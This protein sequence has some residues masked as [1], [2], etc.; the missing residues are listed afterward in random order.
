MDIPWRLPGRGIGKPEKVLGEHGTRGRFLFERTRSLALRDEAT[1]EVKTLINLLPIMQNGMCQ[2][3]EG[4]GL[5]CVFTDILDPLGVHA[6]P[7]EKGQ[8]EQAH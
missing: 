5:R 6:N 2:N 1:T 8:G 4:N 3:Y 7:T